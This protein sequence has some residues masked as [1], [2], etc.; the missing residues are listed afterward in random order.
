MPGEKIMAR[1]S[2]S[3]CG[4]P[5]NRT[6]G[7]LPEITCRDCRRKLGM[8]TSPGRPPK[9]RPL[10]ARSWTPQVVS[11]ATCGIMFEQHQ[12]TQKYCT[13]ACRNKSGPER[14]CAICG[15]AY[16]QRGGMATRTCSRRCGVVLRYG[17]RPSPGRARQ[18]WAP[19]RRQCDVCGTRFLAKN[20]LHKRCSRSCSKEASKRR[21]LDRYRSD[22]AFRDLVI[23]RAQNRHAR[24]LG[25]GQITT[26]AALVAYLM[27]RDH[28]RCGI[29]HQPIRAKTG[30]RR[31]SIDHI[32][33]L[34]PAA[35]LGI[36][37]GEH[38]L[39]NLQAAHYD[40]NLSKGNR[41]CGQP[42]LVG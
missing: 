20:A 30:P 22:P 8:P 12:R 15:K 40:C 37:D 21:T 11:C 18:P 23:S 26:P 29:C 9:P 27:E 2:C 28:R 3:S 34:R 13:I 31:P 33:P 6:K 35:A 5:V 25:V 24:K 32:I 41:Y 19:Q 7:S 1:A 38:Q 16:R 17:P 36:D 14:T 39:E 42:L 4:K 10:R